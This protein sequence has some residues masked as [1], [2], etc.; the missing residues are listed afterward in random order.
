MSALAKTALVL[1][2]VPGSAILGAAAGFAR[3]GSAQIAPIVL[4]F[5]LQGI[6]LTLLIRD[7]WKSP[8]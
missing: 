6:G 4:L 1:L 8:S 7:F 2:L 3:M 5:F